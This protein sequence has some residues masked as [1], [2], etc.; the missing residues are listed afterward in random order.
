[1]IVENMDKTYREAIFIKGIEV[2]NISLGCD[3]AGGY[4]I[5]SSFNCSVL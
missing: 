3:E 2:L 4:P 5:I 1:M